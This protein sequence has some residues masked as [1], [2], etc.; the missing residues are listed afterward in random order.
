MDSILG[1]F[2]MEKMMDD[3]KKCNITACKTHWC[4]I[5][6]IVLLVLATVLTFMTLSGLGIFGMFLAGLMMCCHKHMSSKRCGCGCGCGC[7]CCADTEGMVCE[8]SE[9][10]PVKKVAVK[11]SKA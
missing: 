4:S 5:F 6:G 1:Y 2:G 7:E 3:L 10:D 8:T 11:K 9:K